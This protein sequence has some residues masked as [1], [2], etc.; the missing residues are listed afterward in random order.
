MADNLAHI[1]IV[2][3]L[4]SFLGSKNKPPTGW[5]NA[6]ADP[7]INIALCLI[8][9]DPARHW[10]LDD[11]TTATGMSRSSFASRFKTLVGVP[12]LDYLLRW[13]ML[14]A[15]RKLKFGADRISDVAFSLGY[16]AE[17]SFSN[18]FKRVMGCAPYH[19]R[20]FSSPTNQFINS[21]ELELR[22]R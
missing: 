21:S 19:Y 17:S 16:E 4:R 7:K 13:R 5:L 20:K 10:R 1:L 8:H 6:L 18:A 14:L 22:R 15:A 12:P 2:Q 9:Q 11:F 3:V